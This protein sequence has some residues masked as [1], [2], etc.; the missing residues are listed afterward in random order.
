MVTVATNLDV[1]IKLLFPRP[2]TTKDGKPALAMLGLGDIVIPGLVI[3]MALRW[4]LW[5]FY[6]TKRNANLL[7]VQKLAMEE[8]VDSDGHDIKRRKTYGEEEMALMTK[9]RYIKVTGIFEER[10]WR[11]VEGV[12]FGKEYFL[13]SIG[14]YILGMMTT[15]MVM[16]VWKHAQPALLYLVPGVLGSIWG[17]A[18]WRGELSLMWNYTEE[19]DSILENQEVDKKVAEV[20]ANVEETTADKSGA[21]K[22]EDEGKAKEPEKDASKSEETAEEESEKEEEEEEWISVSVTTKP[23]AG[24]RRRKGKGKRMEIPASLSE[25]VSSSS[26]SSEISSESSSIEVEAEEEN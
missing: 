3:A 22:E 8:I 9:P 12:T 24:T 7:E 5:R 10:F 21:S 15:L 2:G 11:G 13:S 26:G 4:D 20:K 19:G 16:H 17:M 18:A 25:E 23:A 14:G 6:E 1:P